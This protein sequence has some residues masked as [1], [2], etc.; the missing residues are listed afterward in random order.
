[1]KKI[2]HLSTCNT[3]QRIIAELGGL[4]DFE[5][6][7]IKFNNI[8]ART[9]D[10]IADQVRSYEMLFSRRARKFRVLGL[11]DRNLSEDDYRQLILDGYTFLKR[12]VIVAGNE[13][14]V[15]NAKSE[16]ARAKAAI[17]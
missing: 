12:P 14:F 15:G 6:I 3:C 5:H 1:M 13:V 9:L 8:D 16:V 2:Y 10:K 4:K 7:D 11:Q 17:T